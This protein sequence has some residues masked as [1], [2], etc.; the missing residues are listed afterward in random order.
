[1][2]IFLRLDTANPKHIIFCLSHFKVLQR[3]V[4]HSFELCSFVLCKMWKM[5]KAKCILAL[6]ALFI[7]KS[8]TAYSQ[9]LMDMVDTTKTEGRGILGVYKKFDHLKIGGYIQP[10]FQLTS[11]KSAKSYEGGDFGPQTSN[12][13][14]LRRSRIRF[15]YFNTGENNDF[16]F[17]MVFQFDANERVFTVRDVWGRIFENKFKMFSFTTGIFARPFGYEINYSSSDRES[18]ERG[19]MSQILMKSERDIGGMVSF[20]PRRNIPGLN[21]LKIDIGL[22]NGQGINATRDFDNYKDLIAR[23]S[24]KPLRISKKV[25]FAF[26]AST[27]QGGLMQNTKYNY[28]TGLANGIKTTLVDSSATNLYSKSPRVYYG[29]DA[30]LKIKNKVGS[31][32]FKAEYITGKQSGTN[33]SSESPN[34]LLT[35]RDGYNVRNFSGGYLYYVQ[36]LFSTRHQLVVK[37]DWYDPNTDVR[38]NDIG[39]TGSKLNDADIQYNTLG[40]G[41][42]NYLTENI[43]L[44]F[45]YARV[46]NETT[47]LKG[48]T[49]DVKDDVMTFRI[50]YRF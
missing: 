14:M 3:F 35:G 6:V 8:E 9:F 1:M 10:Q 50:Q 4:I 15:D 36:S 2:K 29:A 19:R 48:Y 20:D 27:L 12:R 7:L 5:R 41:Y 40:L 21:K 16:G 49:S 31:S 46:M 17:Q 23:V 42:I 34:A 33:F 43:K 18:P 47:L 32:E 45:Y 13:F 24:V 11:S 37:Y 38:G 44:V 28:Y 26:G 39:V 22:F 30:Q 25:T